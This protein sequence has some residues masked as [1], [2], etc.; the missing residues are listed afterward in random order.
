MSENLFTFN[1]TLNRK[2]FF[3]TIIILI[4]IWQVIHFIEINILIDSSMTMTTLES[5]I[6]KNI[7]SLL[8]LISFMPFAIRRLRDANMTPWWL[9]FW[10]VN[11]FLDDSNVIYVQEIWSFR[12][13]PFDPFSMRMVVS[14]ICYILLVLLLFKKGNNTILLEK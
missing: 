3:I 4:G 11:E 13:E 1:G 7:F 8:W 12:L 14:L 9:L 2:D 5:M 6:Y 10:W